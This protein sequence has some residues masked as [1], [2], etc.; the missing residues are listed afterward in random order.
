M[1]A[2]TPIFS[3]GS[4][5]NHRRQLESDAVIAV[6]ILAQPR[7]PGRRRAH[8]RGRKQL[9]QVG[10]RD[11]AALALALLVECQAEIS[12]KRGAENQESQE[13]QQDEEPAARHPYEPDTTGATMARSAA[14]ML[15]ATMREVRGFSDGRLRLVMVRPM[16]S[17]SS[18]T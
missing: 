18:S 14:M 5:A 16:S 13:A 17:P 2:A 6:L 11:G 10:D 3:A 7:R 15:G 12:M 8:E 1:A 9:D 4:W